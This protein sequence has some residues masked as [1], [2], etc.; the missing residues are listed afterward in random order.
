MMK[1]TI[2]LLTLSL[3]QLTA[4]QELGFMSYNIK[5]DDP[6]DTLNNWESR[7][8]FLISQLKDYAPDIL[9]TQEGMIHQLRDI[10][11]GLEDY[12]FFGVGRDQ[13]NEKGEFTAI[14]YNGSTVDFLEGD[15]FWL[16]NTPEKPSKGWDAAL[17][18]ICTY[19]RFKRKTD[20]KE[21][22]VFNTHFDH[23][24]QRAREESSKLILAQ[25]NVLNTQ[26]VP[27]VLMGDFNL[28]ANS[29]GIRLIQNKMLDTH[30]TAGANAHGPEGTFNGFDFHKP[31]ERRID[32]IFISKN[33]FVVLKSAIINEAKGERYPSDHFPVFTSL[34]LKDK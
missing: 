31:V 26:K 4:A 16:S 17:P 15:T 1:H 2:F 14:F 19:G 22:Y 33:D 24:G 27:V 25:I 3:V 30:V 12:S 34:H 28:E 9:G 11:K 5:F 20:G 8:A 23:I 13:G 29:R 10:E 6:R 21:F 32:F 18:R 7:K